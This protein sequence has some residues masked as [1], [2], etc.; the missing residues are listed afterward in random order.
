M[1]N[2]TTRQNYLNN[3]FLIKSKKVIC[4]MVV[5]LLLMTIMDSVSSSNII[6]SENSNKVT[7]E[8]SE[9]QNNTNLTVYD[10]ITDPIETPPTRDPKTFRRYS[11]ADAL[12]RYFKF[13]GY[14]QTSLFKFYTNYSGHELQHNLKLYRFVDIDVNGDGRPDISVKIRLYPYFE[15]EL[16]FSVNFEYLI[17]RLNNFP[18]I[19]ASFEAYGEIY[20]PGILFKRQRGDRIRIGYESPEGEEV[21]SK[22]DITYKYLTNLIR[23]RKRPEH[24]ALLKPGSSIGTSSLALIFSYT[25]FQ[26]D[27][28]I[29]EVRSRTTFDPAVKSQ[30]TIGG[31]GIFGGST[32]EFIRKVSHDTNINMT[33]AFEKNNTVI[34]GYVKD[35][36]EKVT[37]TIDQGREGFVEFDTHGYPPSEIGLCDDFISPTNFLYFKDLPSQAKIEWKRDIIKDKYIDISLFTNGSGI[38]FLGHLELFT[39][40]SFD[41]NISSKENLDCSLSIDGTEGYFVFDRSAVNV[42]FSLSFININTSFDLSFNLTRFFDKPFEIFF[43]EIV[44]E[45]IQFSLASKSFNLEDFKFIIGLDSGNFGLKAARLLKEKNGSILV[46]F[47]YV[48]GEENTTFILELNVTNG[49]DLYNV[50]LGFNGIWSPPKDI[51]LVGNTSR[52]LEFFCE[53]GGFDY[54]VSEDS[55]WG[56]FYFKGNFSYGSYRT[57]TV[58]NITG[59]FKGKILTRSGDNGLNISWHTVNISGSNITKLNVSG[60]FFGL[61]NFHIF[62]GDK[63]NLL[64]PHLYGNI[65]LREVCKES[66]Y[67]FVE[68]LGGQSYLDFNLSFNFSRETNDSLF[69]LIINVDEF[70][71]SHGDKSAHLEAIWNKKNLSYLVFQTDNNINL[72]IKNMYVLLG[73]NESPIVELKNLTGYLKGYAGFDVVIKTPIIKDDINDTKTLDSSNYSLVFE[74]TDVEIDIEL[75]NLTA[76]VPLGS[77]KIAANAIGTVRLG[78]V[79]ISKGIEK[80]FTPLEVNLSWA[81]I[82]FGM[83]ARNGTLDLDIFE[84]KNAE[85][86]FNFILGFLIPN[87]TGLPSITFAIDNL[88]LNGYSEIA[89]PLGRV[90]NSL[91]FLGFKFDNEVGT[92]FSLDSI[93]LDFPESPIFDEYL[94]LYLDDLKLKEGNFEFIIGFIGLS[95]EVIVADALQSFKIGAEIS[96]LVSINLNLK[97]SVKYFKFEFNPGLNE[98]GEKYVLLDTHNST[99]AL[100]MEAMAS[101]ELLNYFIDIFNDNTN[102]TI[103]YIESDK[104]FSVNN[105]TLK[106]DDFYVYIN[107]SNQSLYKGYLQIFGD[108]SI[109]HIVN[110]SWVPLI[111]GGNGFSFTIEENHLQLKFDMAVE[112]FPVDFEV[113]FDDTGNKILLSGLFTV[114]TDDLTF[115][116]WWNSDDNYLKIISSNNRSLDIENFIFKVFN[117]TAKKIDIQTQFVSIRDGSYDFILDKD[118]N[119]FELEAGGSVL[120][121]EGFVS[122]FNNISLNSIGNTTFNLDFELFELL[123]GSAFFQSHLSS[124]EYNWSIGSNRGIDWFELAGFEA[125]IEGYDKPILH[126]EAGIGLLKWDR[127]SNN[128]LKMRISKNANEGCIKFDRHSNMN[129]SFTIKDIYIKYISPNL[130]IPI[131]TRLRSLSADFRRN[132]HEYFNLEWKKEEY[133]DLDADIA[134]DWKI[135]FERFFDVFNALARI[136]IISSSVDVNFSIHYEPSP[137]NDSEYY[138]GFNVLEKSSIELFEIVNH[139]I[140]RFDKIMTIGKMLLEPGEISFYWII[141]E[142]QGLGWIFIDNHEVTGEFAGI[143]LR[144]G[145]YKIKLFDAS[146]LYPG[147][148]YFEFELNDDSGSL[149]ISNSAEFEFSL[150]EFSEGIEIIKIERDLEFGIISMLPGEFKANWINIS[151]ED[152]DKEL[153]IKNGIFE[154]TFTR[155]TLQLGKFRVSLSLFKIDRVYDNEI[156]LKIRQK[157]KGDRGFSITTDDPLQFD[158]LSIRITGSNWKFIIDLIE[159]KANFNDWYL[160]TWDGKLTIGGNGSINMDGLSRFINI[161]FG[162]RGDDGKTQELFSQYCSSWQNHSQTHALN[163]DTTNCTEQLDL[164]YNTEINNMNIQNRLTINPQKYLTFHF[165]INPE[166]IDGNADG[167]LY[168]DTF[169]EDIGNVAFEISKYV[170]YFDKEIGLYAEIEL[171]KADDFHIWGEFV[172][173]E[174]LGMKFWVPSEWG[175]SGSIDFLNIG[176][177]KLSFGN[178]ETEIWPCKPKAIPE[179]NQYGITPE[180]SVVTFDTSQSEGYAFKLQFMRWDWDG[181]G[182]WDTGSEPY[183][184]IDYK[185]KIDYNFSKLF[186]N[187]EDST[188]VF[189]QLKTVAAKSNIAEVLVSK[190]YVIDIEIQYDDKLYEF[191]EFKV[192]IT[193]ATSNEPISNAYLEYHQ[194]NVDG[195]ENVSSNYTNNNGEV[196][197]TTFEVLYD[198]YIHYSTAQIFIEAE[199]YFDCESAVFNVYD[200]DA[201]LHG[202]IR[203]KITHKGISNAL[204]IAEP[205]GYYTYSEEYHSEMQNGKFKLIVPP[206]IYDIA[207]SKEGFDSVTVKDIN[208]T[209]GGYQY[210]GDIYLPPNG[211]GGLR[212]VIYDAT[213]NDEEI[214]GVTITVIIPGGDDIVTTTNYFGEFPNDYPSPSD[215]YYSIDLEPGTYTVVFEMETYYSHEEQ[216]EIVAGEVIDIEV[217]LFSEWLT[218]YGHN[219]PTEWN[220][221]EDSH[222]DKLNTASY[223]DLYWST[224]WHWT[225]PLELHP[226][227][228]IT[229]NKVR[230]YA[231]HILNRCDQTKI[232][233]FY[234]NAWYEIYKGSFEHK[235]WYEIEFDDEYTISRA[236]VSFRI[237]KYLGIPT[238]AEL[239]EF[240]FG[241]VQP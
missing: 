104:G 169:D 202:F 103:P 154:F 86:I 180:N 23:I 24:R 149:Y 238:I 8:G 143:T 181:D 37:F 150:L 152:F 136:D 218:P 158:L 68:L 161:T 124:E 174:L 28:T 208:A 66:G 32:F 90:N 134:A 185:D 82:T 127:E 191:N 209:L 2:K 1:T 13:R 146:I 121:I 184:W 110:N 239:Y 130:N 67:L 71:L 188:K 114:F 229:C 190:G 43:G 214:Y 212:G 70:H 74:L 38:S 108:G 155:F 14:A 17:K 41:F 76:L 51:F 129:G 21:P 46:N 211:Y 195:S 20:Y 5:F 221:E 101:S 236:R 65:Q 88:S 54:F 22:C 231:K 69:E 9:S 53:A 226:S 72:S 159:L 7:L 26:F 91:S 106:A 183:H 15:K 92:N 27:K 186:E 228:S 201:D 235:S 3:S 160:G 115:D 232:E 50:T 126:F 84:Y 224:T 42:S 97:K 233:I 120:S 192:I 241:L 105:A 132:D 199:G 80:I 153:T 44:G 196:W 109:Y 144:K 219:Y 25:N 78:L 162:W 141:I 147:E 96:N 113:I 48:K 178:H 100:N 75:K 56:Y 151:D 137:D 60:M 118:K 217:Y 193:N 12:K 111:P 85:S 83:D 98:D 216:I 200:T 210:L 142:D 206:E 107:S 116:I 10:E 87:F 189:F 59:G 138:L 18:D 197:F 203:D 63:L 207:T 52:I 112:D 6:N 89:L 128:F 223:T 61:E 131:G 205:G 39:S 47:S 156:T 167:H 240:N 40:S 73:Q 171:L 148:T 163:V 57:F 29:S 94:K 177:V 16:S 30:L 35:L 81:N 123:D 55:S 19:D 93:Y 179:R 213:N 49:I 64:I 79:N 31:N 77:F 36:P 187:E 125:S 145:F 166:P 234:N 230:I 170:D 95:A 227:F 175:K 11:L 173:I 122:E 204:I 194:Y 62:Y 165:D 215:E 198:Y 176:Q 102:L 133:I 34:T 45:Q 119:I 237:R 172:E 58:N 117:N 164:I 135:S 168:I 222:D 4:I 220:D 182:N 33:V 157:G 139:Y 225:E 99:V 140:N